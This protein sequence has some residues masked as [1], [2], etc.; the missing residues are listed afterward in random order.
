MSLHL[1][2][3]L[4]AAASCAAL[5]AHFSRRLSRRLEALS[6]WDKA[7]SALEGA[8]RYQEMSALQAIDRGAREEGLTLPA[9]SERMRARPCQ[10][11]AALL[12]GLP[13][14]PLL[15]KEAQAALADCL[16]SLFEPTLP[17]QARGIALAKPPFTRCLRSAQAARD[18]YG[19]LY[20]SLG[21]MAGAALFILLC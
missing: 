14:H 9:L 18:A 11:S 5:G 2:F 13:W 6:Q 8:V 15:P 1:F 10:S 12:D 7:L 17:Q 21:W 3:A 4:G 16:L 20:I 19:R